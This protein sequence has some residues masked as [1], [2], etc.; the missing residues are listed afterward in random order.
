MRA[1]SLSM[2]LLA[3][4]GVST[5]T[6]AADSSQAS[7]QLGAQSFHWSEFGDN[8]VR[9]LQEQG[10]RFSVGAA[11]DN[12]QR[13]DSGVLYNVNGKF[14]LGSVDYDGQTQSGVPISLSR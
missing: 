4:L 2:V 8:G 9:L 3:V 6:Q 13:K 7:V 14:Y 1:Q 11:Y 5:V 12:F 10:A